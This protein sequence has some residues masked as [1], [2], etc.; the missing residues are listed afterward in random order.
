MPPVAG[1]GGGDGVG[2]GERLVVG[3]ARAAGGAGG[4]LLLAGGPV[5]GQD[6]GQLRAVSTGVGQGAVS[7]D[8]LGELD[9]GVGAALPG[10]APVT[11]PALR[12][13]G[14]RAVSRA[15]LSRRR[16]GTGRAG[17]RQPLVVR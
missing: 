5:G 14:S 8:L 13:S 12:A 9:E 3:A 16:A 17:C 7:Q 6:V 11:V 4:V 1:Q 15:S 2:E 10:G